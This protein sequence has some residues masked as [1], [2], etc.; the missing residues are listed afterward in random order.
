MASFRF[1]GV[2][3]KEE[4]QAIV[5][6]DYTSERY[7]IGDGQYSEELRVDDSPVVEIFASNGSRYDE[8][9]EDADDVLPEI[10]EQ[11]KEMLASC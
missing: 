2:P 6:G 11:A 9:S 8:E 1:L 4:L 7:P 5:D 10:V 3:T